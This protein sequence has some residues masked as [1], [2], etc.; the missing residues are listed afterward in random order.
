MAGLSSAWHQKMVA[1]AS[2]KPVL[3]RWPVPVESHQCGCSGGTVA[4]A[5]TNDAESIPKHL[6]ASNGAY[7]LTRVE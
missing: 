6:V 7:V 5:F 1:P 3:V 4:N 2:T